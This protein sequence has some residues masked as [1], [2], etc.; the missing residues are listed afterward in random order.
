MIMKWIGQT[1][2]KK[3]GLEWRTK[4]RRLFLE[5]IITE[6]VNYRRKDFCPESE[7]DWGDG[8]QTKNYCLFLFESVT[9][10]K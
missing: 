9:N 1:G 7:T 3:G 4:D 8:K 10:K 6:K 2:N 5:K